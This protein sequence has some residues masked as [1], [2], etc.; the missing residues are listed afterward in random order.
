M[1]FNSN[2]LSDTKRFETPKVQSQKMSFTLQSGM[3]KISY[4]TCQFSLV[5]WAGNHM[6]L[7]GRPRFKSDPWPFSHLSSPLFLSLPPLSCHFFTVSANK[8]EKDIFNCWSWAGVFTDLDSWT[9][10]CVQSQVLQFPCGR[11]MPATEV[12]ADRRP[13]WNSYTHI[14]IWPQ[15]QTQLHICTL[16]RS[17]NA[18]TR[19]GGACVNECGVSV[20][21]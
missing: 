1:I 3:S 11:L 21:R 4:G 10:A 12:S 19:G 5:H 2:N 17:G 15:A 18:V 16:P 13:T 6:A 7:N 20:M 8:A 14:Q 9:R